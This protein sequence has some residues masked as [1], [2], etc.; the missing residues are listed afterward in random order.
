VNRREKLA[1]IVGQYPVSR[2]HRMALTRRINVDFFLKRDDELGWAGSKT[3]KYVSLVPFLK[4]CGFDTVIVAGSFYSN[5]VPALCARLLESG[6]APTAFLRGTGPW[7]GNAMTTRIFLPHSRIFIVPKSDDVHARAME[8]AEILRAD[9]QKVF[10]VPEGAK[11]PAALTGAASLA[12]DLPEC[13]FLFLDAG[14]GTTAAAVVLALKYLQSPIRTFVALLAGNETEFSQTVA[15]FHPFLTSRLGAD[16]D[17]PMAGV[18]YRCLPAT[19]AFGRVSADE[20][21]LVLQWAR[22][23][24]VL[25]DPVYSAKFLTLVAQAIDEH[26]LYGKI[27]AVHSGG[28]G[29]LHGFHERLLKLC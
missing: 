10:V 29:T 16:F 9:G 27:V 1:G 13:D 2:V 3:R 4:S 17:L 14:S 11:T 26:R 21:R 8:H 24:G 12:L 23:Y 15:F 6:M 28:W 22:R 20:L 18:D 19:T 5:H 7:V 25:T